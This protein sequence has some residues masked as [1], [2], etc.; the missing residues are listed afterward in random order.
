MQRANACQRLEELRQYMDLEDEF[1]ERLRYPAETLSATL[2][3]RM[4]DGSLALLKAWRCRYN[5]SRGPTKGGIRFHPGVNLEEVMALSFWMT[6]KCAVMD[7][8]F[9]G[10]KGGVQVDTKKLSQSE[11]ER[12]SRKFIQHFSS[13]IGPDRDIPAPDMY[14]NEQVMAWMLDEYNQIAQQHTPAVITG[15]PLALHGSPGREEAT[16]R[17]A[18]Y[19]LSALESHLELTPDNTRVIFQGFGNA[20][21]HNAQLL[22]E[23]GYKIVGIGDS[24][25]AIYDHSGMEPY[26][27]FAHKQKHGSV[28]EAPTLGDSRSLDAEEVLFQDCDLLIPAALGDQITSTNAHK[29]CCRAILEIAN[30]AVSPDADAILKERDIE[31]IPDILAN[32]GGVTVSHMEWMQNRMGGRWKLS[33]VRERLQQTMEEQTLNVLEIATRDKLPLKKAAYKLAV[34][35]ISEAMKAGSAPN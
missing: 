12:V 13:M 25:A 15:K 2:P 26:Q 5:D 18:Y 28:N 19:V 16:G 1:Y 32:A 11:L 34:G 31:V 17:G 29:I 23:A 21:I 22:Y 33:E 7:I 9:G 4:D 20:A 10:A 6:L 3:V 24:S 27:V 14:T 30:G 35:R 8:P